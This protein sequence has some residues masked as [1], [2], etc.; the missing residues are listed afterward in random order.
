M[1]SIDLPLRNTGVHAPAKSGKTR[2][3][4]RHLEGDDYELVIDWSSIESFTTCDRASEFRL[5]MSRS[6]YPSPPLI[7]GQ[8]IHAALEVYYKNDMRQDATVRHHML[9]AGEKVL[10]D[11][12]IDM[13]WRNYGHFVSAIDRYLKKYQRETFEVLEYQSKPAV[14]LS[15]AHPLGVLTIDDT[16]KYPRKQLV[17]DAEEDSHFYVNRIHV[18]WSGVIDLLLRDQGRLFVLDHKTASRTGESYFRPFDLSQQMIGYVWAASH[19][20]GE[21]FSGAIINVLI[22]RQETKTGVAWDQT[23]D[24]KYYSPERIAEWQSNMLHILSDF[25]HNL[26][27]GYFP[28]KTQWC[29]GKFGMCPFIDVCTLTNPQQQ[30]ALLFSSMF[31][32]NTWN[33]L[34]ESTDV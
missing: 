31:T 26:M 19:L 24:I 10:L 22:G 17:I 9:E 1:L 7:Y 2:K 29:A 3:L 16:L 30:L 33:P 28:M 13:G 20:F 14:E 27:R 4:L 21:Q 32:S 25:A 12:P 34:G 8:A 5:V 6:T 15:F 23:R 18:V 11:N